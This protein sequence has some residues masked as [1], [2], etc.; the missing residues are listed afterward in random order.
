LRIE[1]SGGCILY[2]YY[3]I[4]LIIISDL[5]QE[6]RKT[7]SFGGSEG[8]QVVTKCGI[9]FRRMKFKIQHAE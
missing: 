4:H 3:F 9:Y 7:A 1:N 2:F 6:E 8:A 5:P